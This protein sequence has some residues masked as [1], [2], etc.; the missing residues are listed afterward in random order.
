LQ[1][2]A[3]AAKAED[4]VNNVMTKSL[5]M[6]HDFTSTIA[7]LAPPKESN[8]HLMPGAI[9]VLVAAM[10]GSIVTR[11]WNF[12]VR[13]PAPLVTGAIAANYVLPRT[14]H[15]VGQLAWEYE[16]KAP[17]LANAHQATQDRVT[18]FLATGKAHSQVGLDQVAHWMGE[19][20]RDVER[21]V[22]KGN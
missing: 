22:K 16:K 8:E 15:N 3:Q 6:E 5:K 10:A 11:R 14:S 2:H 21:W 17:V 18:Q 20:T 19:R 4:W 12:L 13:W 9:Y 1:I 7:S